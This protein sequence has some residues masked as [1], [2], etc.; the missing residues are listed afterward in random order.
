[1][2]LETGAPDDFSQGVLRQEDPT[3]RIQPS[4]KNSELSL[5]R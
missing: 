4:R 5:P 1:M 2:E 3:L